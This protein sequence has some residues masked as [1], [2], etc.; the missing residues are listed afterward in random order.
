MNPAAV[1]YVRVSSEEQVRGTSLA[2]QERDCRAACARLGFSVASVYRD[3]GKSAKS[4]VGRDGLAAAVAECQRTGAALVV[5][6]FDRLARNTADALSVRDALLARG[7]RIV[8]CTEGEA[9]ASPLAKAMF[10]M[11]SI[12]AELDNAQ[13][14][15]RSRRGM[16]ERAEAGGWCFRAPVGFVLARTPAGVPVLAP[17][18]RAAP[19][20]RAAFAA[21][22]DGSARELDAARRIMAGT[23]CTRKTAYAMLRAPIYKG[24]LPAGK[25]GPERAAAFPG[26]VDAATWDAAQAN[27]STAQVGIRRMKANPATPLAGVLFCA[28]CGHA[29]VGGFSRGRHGGRHGYYRC[30]RCGVSIRLDKAEADVRA[31]L[32]AVADRRDCLAGIQSNLAALEEIEARTKTRNAEIAA[33]RRE[34]TKQEGRLA[35]AREAFVAGSFTLAEFDA[36]RTEAEARLREARAT[37]ATADKWAGRREEFVN[38]LL[39]IAAD[40]DRILAL[41]PVAVKDALRALCGRVL[42]TRD[43]ALRFPSDSAVEILRA[44]PSADSAG[45]NIRALAPPRGIEPRLPG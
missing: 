34:V 13:R 18:E 39:E 28:E 26:L 16:A 5:Y 24:V 43:K 31:A 12:F 42:V 10:G 4:T 30:P 9:A 22:A 27:L 15:E 17:D 21:L 41:P 20:I 11:A 19:A 35:R 37:I 23:G 40:P 38:A 36:F 32:R 1:I 45:F 7:C 2:T 44:L 8:S 25:L 29:L 33:A 14:A 3:E 6:K